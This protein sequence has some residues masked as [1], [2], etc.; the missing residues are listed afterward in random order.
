MYKY[1]VLFMLFVTYCLNFIDR[2]LLA[3]LSQ[4]IQESLLLNDQQ[5]GLLGGVAFVLLYSGLSLPCAIIADRTNRVGMIALALAVWSGMTALCGAAQ[6]F[7]Q[8][9]LA[10]LGVG[11]GEAGGV[12]PSYAIVGE[13]FPAGRKALALSILSVGAPVGAAVGL[14]LGSHLAEYF[15]WRWAFIIVGLLGL[16]FSPLFALSVRESVRKPLATTESKPALLDGALLLVRQR[17]FW[18]MS[19]GAGIGSMGTFSMIFWLPSMLQRT[20]GYSLI[21]AGQAVGLIILVG[22]IIGIIAGGLLGDAL[23]K[24]DRGAYPRVPGIAFLLAAPLL[25]L[26]LIVEN[27]VARIATLLLAYGLTA[28]WLA[29]VMAVTQE[30]VPLTSRATASALLLLI[31]NLML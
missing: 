28:V 15:D 14:V 9:G 26:G 30:L 22:G 29:P 23:G 5:M 2:Q 1:Y 11:V 27:D 19:I 6:N 25:V 31:S 24:L 20:Y 17:V 13:Y 12:A 10:R 3:I 21:Q 7:W 16:I 8:L 4:P 18:L